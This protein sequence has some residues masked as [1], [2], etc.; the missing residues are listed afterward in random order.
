MNTGKTAECWR[1]VTAMGQ[2]NTLVLV[3]WLNVT[4]VAKQGRCRAVKNPAP[5]S[6]IMIIPNGSTWLES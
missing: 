6:T 2:G 4:S 5:D 1:G 3:L